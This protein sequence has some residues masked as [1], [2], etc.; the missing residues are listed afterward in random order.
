M[1]RVL[2]KLVA[3]YYSS[4]IF[5]QVFDGSSQDNDTTANL[6]MEREDG[7]PSANPGED[8]RPGRERTVRRAGLFQGGGQRKDFQGSCRAET[9]REAVLVHEDRV[10]GCVRGDVLFQRSGEAADRGPLP[11]AVPVNQGND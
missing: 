1:V 9:H 2:W 3:G 7:G 4:G 5:R 8:K 6:R 10:S 11:D